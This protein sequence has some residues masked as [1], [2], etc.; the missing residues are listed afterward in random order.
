MPAQIQPSNWLKNYNWKMTK[1]LPSG[2]GVVYTHSQKSNNEIILYDDGRI[3]HLLNNQK[4]ASI[5]SKNIQGYLAK[6]HKY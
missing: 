5:D 2:N 6:L 1:N 3:E 4:I